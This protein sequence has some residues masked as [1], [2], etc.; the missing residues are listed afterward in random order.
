MKSARK[1][2]GPISEGRRTEESYTLD[3]GMSL[4][5][6]RRESQDRVQT[7]DLHLSINITNSKFFSG[8]IRT[9]GTSEKPGERRFQIQHQ[10]R[11]CGSL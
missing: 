8:R 1:P 2:C 7:H 9:H 3:L 4:P 11:C 6:P 5:A 10:N